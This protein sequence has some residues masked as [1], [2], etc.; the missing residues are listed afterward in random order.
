MQVPETGIGNGEVPE[1]DFPGYKVQVLVIPTSF[2]AVAY[3]Y[4]KLAEQVTVM[5]LDPDL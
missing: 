4:N 3:S 5:G 2:K 1:P